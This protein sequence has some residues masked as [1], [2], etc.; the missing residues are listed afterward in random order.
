M[1]LRN[2]ASHIFKAVIPVEPVSLSRLRVKLLFSTTPR[3]NTFR[4]VI[5][6]L[7]TF[8]F[9]VYQWEKFIAFTA[10][11]I[12]TTEGYLSECPLL[13]FF[14]ILSSQRHLSGRRDGGA[15]WN[16]GGNLTG[17]EGS[18]CFKG[19]PGHAPQ[20]KFWKTVSSCEFTSIL[21]MSPL[22]VSMWAP[23]E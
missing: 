1:L 22:C 21:K 20:G 10:F 14:S 8:V 23:C 13:I 3:Y 11:N 6:Q 7:S 5:Y 15:K 9:F 4:H 19:G 2:C 18:E 17:L 16:L 12:P